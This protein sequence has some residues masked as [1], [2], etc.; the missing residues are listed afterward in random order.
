V[1]AV[2]KAG[3]ILHWNGSAW[4]TVPSP[5]SADLDAVFGADACDVWAV[6]DRGAVLALGR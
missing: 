2:G 1:W 5:T 4:S 6:G 3:T